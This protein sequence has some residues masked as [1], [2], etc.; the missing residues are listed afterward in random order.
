M[1]ERLQRLIHWHV[2]H[3]GETT[4]HFCYL[5]FTFIEAHGIHAMFAGGVSVFM[6]AGLLLKGD[7]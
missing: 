4:C 1:K 5:A 6:I 3:K 7:E 2:M